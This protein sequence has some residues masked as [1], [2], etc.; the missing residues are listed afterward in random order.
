V[1]LGRRSPSPPSAAAGVGGWSC[2]VLVDA[3]SDMWLVRVRFA[4]RPRRG[5]VFWFGGLQW[6]V[7]RVEPFGCRAVPVAM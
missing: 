3:G 4:E 6:Q 2:L 7:D 1:D 5:L